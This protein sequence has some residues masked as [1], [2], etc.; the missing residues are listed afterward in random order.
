MDTPKTLCPSAPM[1][2]GSKLIG[3]VNEQGEVNVLPEPL[4]ITE[5][6]VDAALK[7]RLPEQRFRFANKCVKSGCAQWTGDS[8][9]VIKRFLADIDAKNLKSELPECAIRPNC[10]WFNQEGESACKACPLIK[11]IY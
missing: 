7:G 11:Y 1:Y 2:E 5:A 6:F 10:R 4:E 9:S 8:C 3:I